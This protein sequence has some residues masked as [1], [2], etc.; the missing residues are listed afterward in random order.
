[1][2]E[3]ATPFDD[4]LES[5][6]R[7]ALRAVEA[8]DLP[9]ASDWDR[10]DGDDDDDESD[11]DGPDVLPF[12]SASQREPQR[13]SR[14]QPDV[15]SA[16]APTPV[17]ESV[18]RVSPRQILEAAVFVGG[19]ELSAERLASLLKGDF[20]PEFV[21]RTLDELNRKYAAENRPYEIRRDEN[22]F[23]LALRADYEPLRRRVYGLGPKEVKLGQEALEILSLIAYRQPLSRGEIESL[24]EGNAGNVL[25]QLVR[26]QLVSVRRS[27]D[28]NEAAY[29]TT[30]RFL[31]VF[32]IA[33]L[34]ELPRAEDLNF[35]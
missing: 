12:P 18:S 5:A 20:T 21:V 29:V 9:G 22:L 4:D 28:A 7:Q 26:R 19:I 25:R 6:Y 23:R 11:V 16:A 24:R 27:D 33:N 32:G 14:S 30:D 2:T 1:M 3:D 17:A 35:K 34:D 15:K 8:A 31:E 13:E 10:T